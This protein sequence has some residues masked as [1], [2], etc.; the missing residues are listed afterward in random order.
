MAT[1]L[2]PLAA[3]VRFHKQRYVSNK[4]I[5][6]FMLYGPNEPEY[7]EVRRYSLRNN[8]LLNNHQMN[9][10]IQNLVPH[11]QNIINNNHID[12]IDHYVQRPN[13]PV[14][15]V[16]LRRLRCIEDIEQLRRHLQTADRGWV[17]SYPVDQPNDIR[18]APIFVLNDRNYD[19]I[20]AIENQKLNP[21]CLCNI[22]ENSAIFT[23]RDANG[24][25][26]DAGNS[27]HLQAPFC[28]VDFTHPMNQHH[29]YTPIAV[30]DNI[31]GGFANNVAAL[32][33]G[34]PDL[35][36][37]PNQHQRGLLSYRTWLGHNETKS[38]PATYEARVNIINF[39]PYYTDY[40]NIQL[41]WSP[42]MITRY[43]EWS[44]GTFCIIPSNCQAGT[45]WCAQPHNLDKVRMLVN[46]TPNSYAQV[47]QANTINNQMNLPQINNA[48]TNTTAAAG[49]VL[50]NGNYNAQSGNA[51]VVGFVLDTYFNI[52]NILY[53]LVLIY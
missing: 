33:N 37:P 46:P 2:R 41:N 35:S 43:H 47:I 50:S 9:N 14:N 17:K 10:V 28:H 49:L 11:Y 18:L 21:H 4:L 7:Q 29:G 42:E 3:N 40:K 1:F 27:V 39:Q 5:Q 12:A 34:N 36:I 26:H 23:N 51:V 13:A 16:P 32:W 30:T 31:H 8:N 15:T 44:N 20:A 22:A 6:T 19:R 24:I 53:P 52:D 25:Y 48:L 45:S 38:I